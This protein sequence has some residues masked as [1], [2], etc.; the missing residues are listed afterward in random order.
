MQCN[1]AG[2]CASEV[3]KEEELEAEEFETENTKAEGEAPSDGLGDEERT[4]IL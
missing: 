3:E 2:K 1:G 4:M